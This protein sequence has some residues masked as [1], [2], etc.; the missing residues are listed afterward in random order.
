MR[1]GFHLKNSVKTT[2]HQQI[3]H[4]K[5]KVPAD[6]RT[7]ARLPFRADK[8]V[9]LTGDRV[10][11]CRPTNALQRVPA[12]KQGGV[13]AGQI[14]RSTRHENRGDDQQDGV[15]IAGGFRPGLITHIVSTPYR[16]ASPAP[17]LP[18][19]SNRATDQSRSARLSVASISPAGFPFG[20]HPLPHHPESVWSSSSS[21]VR[22]THSGPP[23]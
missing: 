8:T 1:N 12:S 18:P 7:P 23:R 15:N 6:P 21:T 17:S 2:T 14:D 5:S 10:G 19:P 16:A 11:K 3:R 13:S 22:P 4:R 9:T 20:G